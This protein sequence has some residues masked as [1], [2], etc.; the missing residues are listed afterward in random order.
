MNS[1]DSGASLTEKKRLTAGQV[2]AERRE[3][4][5]LTIEECAETLK[6]SVSTMKALEAD[7][8]THF[9][10]EIFLRGYLKNYAKLVDLPINDVLYYYDSQRQAVSGGVDSVSFQA[11]VQSKRKWWLP[12]VLA[13]LIIAAWFVV[14]NDIE[15]DEYLPADTPVLN[16][17]AQVSEQSSHAG[18]LLLKN[19]LDASADKNTFLSN[20]VSIGIQ[21]F[22]EAEVNDKDSVESEQPLIQQQQELK[23]KQEDELPEDS[24][25]F[26]DTDK[27]A[28]VIDILGQDIVSPSPLVVHQQSGNVTNDSLSLRLGESFEGVATSISPATIESELDLSK[29]L[30]SKT[31]LVN[32]LLYFTFLEA[33]WV[34]V[35]DA[36]NKTIVSSIRKANSELLVEGRSPFSIVLGN[37]NGATLRFNDKPIDLANSSDGRTIRLTVGG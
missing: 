23:D 7:N 15:L 5:G 29:A 30:T 16:E 3:K 19:N 21:L 27:A 13:V 20:E 25:T 10:S 18:D 35:V 33:C 17:P 24:S 28:S 36:T 4:L 37:I 26:S 22:E 31:S 14:S 34:E 8:D 6:L 2:L 1:H 11:G 32:D 9:P 12:Y